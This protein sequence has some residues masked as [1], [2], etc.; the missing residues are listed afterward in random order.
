MRLIILIAI[1]I[2]LNCFA[3]DLT[4]EEKQ[5][6]ILNYS[7]I[8][9]VLKSDGL[10]ETQAKKQKV[11]SEIKDT[12]KKINISRYNYPKDS[13]Y[14]KFI[15]ELWLV[16]NVQKLRWDF[17]KPEYGLKLAFKQL[18]EKFS[19]YNIEFKILIIN[20][21][22]VAHFGLPLGDNSYLFILSL[23]FMRSLDLTKVDISL[24]LLEDFLRLRRN[25][26]KEN[27]NLNLKN[28]AGNFYNKKIDK[29][30]IT[31]ALNKYDE[32][33]FNKGF[34]FQQQFELT[35]EVDQL[36]KSEPPLWGAYF[37][38]YTKIDRFIKTDILYKNY[39]KIYPSPEMRLKWLSP[40]KEV[41]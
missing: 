6:Q 16:K 35:K 13:D 21:P 1:S 36:L 41:I 24:L 19:F 2:S 34:T 31:G 9:S 32:V 38:L 40:K 25:Q 15:T 26:F 11:I 8:K 37:K 22:N 20:T 27:L 10:D 4:F 12:R 39:L 18:L 29:T 17:P 30:L 23:P 28:L 3:Q 7:N 14:W 5:D 33:V